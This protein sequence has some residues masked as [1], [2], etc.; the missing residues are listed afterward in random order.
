MASR[1]MA[2]VLGFLILASCSSKGPGIYGRSYSAGSAA[3]WSQPPGNEE[4]GTNP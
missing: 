3:G 4:Y 1:L 2:G